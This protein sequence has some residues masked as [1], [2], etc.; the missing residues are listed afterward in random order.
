MHVKFAPLP[1]LD[2]DRAIDFYR[3]HFGMRV[4]SDAPY[5]DNWRWVE[6]AFPGGGTRL[7]MQR[8]ADEGASGSP[9]LSLIVEDVDGLYRNMRAA[10]VAFQGEPKA[11]PWNKD[12]LAALFTDSEGNLVLLS[13]PM[14][15]N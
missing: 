10:G 8:K 6:L 12:E 13:Q 1:V 15:R 11:P 5:S 3:T 4:A 14:K 2:Q 9:D 7:L